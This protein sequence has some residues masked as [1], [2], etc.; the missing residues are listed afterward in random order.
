MNLSGEEIGI[1]LGILSIGIAIYI[2]W[3]QHKQMDQQK[4]QI[5]ELTK[6]GEATK[7]IGQETHQTAQKLKSDTYIREIIDKFFSVQKEENHIYKC[8]FLC[9][10]IGNRFLL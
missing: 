7:K 2:A 6:I 4:K 8:F 5:E 3:H 10:M 9:I 1:F